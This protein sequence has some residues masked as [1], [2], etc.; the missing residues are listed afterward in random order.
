M[1]FFGS[2]EEAKVKTKH[3]PAVLRVIWRVKRAAGNF[4][5]LEILKMKGSRMQV[6]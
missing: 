4:E 6:E 5:M 3:S 1:I 2:P